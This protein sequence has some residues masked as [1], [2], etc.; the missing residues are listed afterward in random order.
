MTTTAPA[1]LPHH[2]L[3]CYSDN[4]TS[5]AW[6]KNCTVTDDSATT[7]VP[8]NRYGVK[9]TWK[10]TAVSS[11]S[12]LYNGGYNAH[13]VLGEEY[14]VSVYAK[15]SNHQ[16]IAVGI[17]GNATHITHFDIQNGAIGDSTAG[18]LVL[19]PAIEDMGGGWYYITFIY[20]GNTSMST[21]FRLFVTLKS[22]STLADG[23][24]P[25]GSEI[26][27]LSSPQIQSFGSP[28]YT[29]PTRDAYDDPEFE[30]YIGTTSY[31]KEWGPARPC[32]A[33]GTSS[34]AYR[35]ELADHVLRRNTDNIEASSDGDTLDA[36]SLYGAVAHTKHKKEVDS[37]NLKT[38]KSDGTTE[39]DS[40]PITTSTSAAPIIGVD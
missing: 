8:P 17:S 2:N 19:E 22:G 11:T 12:M 26:L 36:L 14:R 9:Y 3:L 29:N 27:Y 15:Y 35:N 13:V 5:S 30:K 1:Y 28:D 34:T 40:R 38:Y 4:I 32:L 31:F 37:G 18:S 16:W 33:A 10:I 21:G 7:L 23:H 6:T 25:T 39:L 20:V 24:T